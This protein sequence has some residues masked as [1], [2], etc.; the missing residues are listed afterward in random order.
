MVV[1]FDAPGVYRCIVVVITDPSAVAHRYPL[2]ITTAQFAASPNAS[3]RDLVA[4][5]HRV[6][7]G[8]LMVPIDP[9][10]LANWEAYRARRRTELSIRGDDPRPQRAERDPGED[11][12]A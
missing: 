3:R 8:A 11:G 12:H 7:E 5:A 2:D 9:R 4:L 6:L 10:Q 1:C